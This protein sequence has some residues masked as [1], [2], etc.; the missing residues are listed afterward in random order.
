MSTC[1]QCSNLTTRAI[2]KHKKWKVHW[3]RISKMV[4]DPA[5]SR[6]IGRLDEESGKIGKLSKENVAEC[7]KYGWGYDKKNVESDTIN[8][9]GHRMCVRATY[10][11]YSIFKIPDG[12]DLEDKSVVEEWYVKWDILHIKYASGKVA[13]IEPTWGED[14]DDHKN[15]NETELLAAEEE[16]FEDEADK[17]DEDAEAE[18]LD[19]D[20]ED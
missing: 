16:G 10:N 17:V 8:K 20:C 4:F 12:V 19:E 6:A 1:D 7:E 18:E 15:P 5:T 14:E 9:K 13:E 11:S 2:R 3:D